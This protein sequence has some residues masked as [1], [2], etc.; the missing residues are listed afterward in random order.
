VEGDQEAGLWRSKDGRAWRIG[1]EAEV[2]WIDERTPGGLAITS[3]V[4][5]VFAAYATLELPGTGNQEVTSRIDE[6]QDRH[7]A[8]VLAILR[9]HA[10]AQPWWLGYLE[11]GASDVVFFDAPRVKMY[12]DWP[13][14]LVAAG[15]DQA[16]SWRAPGWKGVL[17]DLI[18]PADRSW[19]VSTLWDDEWTC[20]GGPRALV[21]A[22]LTH[23]DLRDRAREVDPSMEDSTP[24]GHTAF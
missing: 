3:A 7:D 24:P 6:L 16:G 18:F 1:S 20:I 19:L 15:P 9:E 22:F 11:S 12:A 8:V 14:V 10:A 13:Y 23:P 21:D 17:P 2:A 5:P 4:P